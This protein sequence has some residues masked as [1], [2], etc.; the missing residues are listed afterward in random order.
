MTSPTPFRF[1]RR[2][3][4]ALG[5]AALV[6]FVPL[7]AR[8]SHATPA[9]SWACGDGKPNVEGKTCDCPAGE[10]SVTSAKGV[11]QCVRAARPATT[12][13]AAPSTPGS[14]KPGT[15]DACVAGQVSS[16]GH[17]CWA[18]Q[19]WNAKSSK[20]TGAVRCP[21][22]M[23][24]EGEGCV[25]ECPAGK[26]AVAG[27]CC[28]PG[29]D[30]GAGASRC[31]GKPTCPIGMLTDGD[32]CIEGCEGGK[33]L[34][35]GHCCWP[36][37]DWGV[38]ARACI[39]DRRCPEG[40]VAMGDACAEPLETRKARLAAAPMASIAGGDLTLPSEPIV[41]AIEAGPIWNSGHA[42]T[43]CPK[44]CAR[45][46]AFGYTGDWTTIRPKE[47]SVCKCEFAQGTTCPGVR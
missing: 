29:Q 5:V 10:V 42:Q 44:V 25:A 45:A 39:G 19:E 21:E 1:V 8:D 38:T 46:H 11:A 14:T 7:L 24:G 43:L 23:R 22:P 41:C 37:Q 18:G 4:A 17:C 31:I 47:M 13:T 35:A 30:W 28:W 40:T 36:G 34:V 2:P 15:L 16:H 3:L 32:R 33:H 12:S 26:L 27:H 9:T 20:C 6:A